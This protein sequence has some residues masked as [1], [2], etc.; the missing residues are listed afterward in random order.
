MRGVALMG[1]FGFMGQVAAMVGLA[2]STHPTKRI[3]MGIPLYWKNFHEL[4]EPVFASES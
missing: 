1:G 4:S 3:M 2:D